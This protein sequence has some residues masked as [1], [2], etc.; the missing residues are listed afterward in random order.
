MRLVRALLLQLVLLFPMTAFGQVVTDG[1][2]NDVSSDRNFTF[3][4]GTRYTGQLALRGNRTYFSLDAYD[5][6]Q[7]TQYRASGF[8][9]DLEF[10]INNK[11]A[12]PLPADT[13]VGI[14]IIRLYT[15]DTVDRRV[16][17][18][19]NASWLNSLGQP[20]PAT[21]L[22]G[23]SLDEF[24]HDHAADQ[25]LDYLARWHAHPS[26]RTPSSWQRR[27]A[28][29]SYGFGL[30]SNRN[31]YLPEHQSITAA[32][33][34]YRL[35]RFSESVAPT[36]EKAVRFTVQRHGSRFLLINVFTPEEGK[37]AYQNQYRLEFIR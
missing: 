22:Q 36:P 23:P 24:V 8:P 33:G 30:S 12:D 1:E 15:F 14:E 18:F 11:A 17:L 4:A 7:G 5:G 34:T 13:Y 26:E 10:V 21:E 9:S 28:I 19:R 16:N 29:Y 25:Q 32:Q 27:D 3:F 20:L 31:G 6:T 37:V 35:I 2:G